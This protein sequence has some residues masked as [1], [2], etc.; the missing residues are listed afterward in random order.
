MKIKNILF[1]N[2]QYFETIEKVHRS[3]QLSG[4]ELNQK[5]IRKKF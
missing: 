1:E 4:M 5:K 2:K 3:D